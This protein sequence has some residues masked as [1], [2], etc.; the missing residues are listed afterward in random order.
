[1][2]SDNSSCWGHSHIGR[3]RLVPSSLQPRLLV[4]AS[5]ENA[6]YYRDDCAWRTLVPGI[7]DLGEVFCPG[8]LCT[9]PSPHRSDSSWWVSLRS[10]TIHQ[11][12][13]CFV[14]VKLFTLS[15]IWQLLGYLFYFLSSSG[16]QSEY[17]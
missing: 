17:L 3:L 2:S 9:I 6:S 5:L 15:N 7:W 1:M 11:L 13:V 16:I 14:L 4:S 10:D 8:L 12:L